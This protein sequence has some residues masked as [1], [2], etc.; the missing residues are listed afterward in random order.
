MVIELNDEG[1]IIRVDVME[2]LENRMNDDVLNELLDEKDGDLAEAFET[3]VYEEFVSVPTLSIDDQSY[4]KSDNFN[5]ILSER[6]G[7][8]D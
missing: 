2:Y 5:D 8:I 3:A 7:E 4:C 6:L 1:A